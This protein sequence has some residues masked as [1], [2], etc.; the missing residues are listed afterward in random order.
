MKFSA[1]MSSK[2]SKAIKAPKSPLGSS[3]RSATSFGDA[4]PLTQKKN[5]A[6]SKGKAAD[7]F[8]QISFGAT[9][10]TGRD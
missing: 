2:S 1:K 7:Q 8:G 9:G 6:K 10:T 4:S 5:Y 3:S